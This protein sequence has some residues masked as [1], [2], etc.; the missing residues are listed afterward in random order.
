VLKD[1]IRNDGT[2]KVLEISHLLTSTTS[3]AGVPPQIEQRGGGEGDGC[4]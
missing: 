3:D 4:S 2:W 1:G